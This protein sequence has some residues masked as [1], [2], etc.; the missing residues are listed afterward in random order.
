[1]LE[2]LLVGFVLVKVLDI[3]VEGLALSQQAILVD[4]PDVSEVM[5]ADC[6]FNCVE[7]NGLGCLATQ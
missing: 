5:H 3:S 1:M 7:G 6:F 4:L 2:T